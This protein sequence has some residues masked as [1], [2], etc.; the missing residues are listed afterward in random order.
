MDIHYNY[1]L[2]WAYKSPENG[3][4]GESEHL[5]PGTSETPEHLLS[6][7]F[8]VLFFGYFRASE[9]I[10]G[11]ENH[12]DRHIFALS[13]QRYLICPNRTTKHKVMTKTDF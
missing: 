3:E 1:D 12:P 9:K 5:I 6:K 4:S 8:G 13:F 7:S 10:L 11:F 2:K